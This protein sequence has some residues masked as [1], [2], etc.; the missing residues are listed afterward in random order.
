MYHVSSQLRITVGDMASKCYLT[1]PSGQCPG[2]R[3]LAGQKTVPVQ[4]EFGA[5]FGIQVQIFM[6]TTRVTVQV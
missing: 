5:V 4:G 3:Q 6:R 1:Q 2:T